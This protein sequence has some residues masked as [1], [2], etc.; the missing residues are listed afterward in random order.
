MASRYSDRPATRM[1]RE[2]R[3]VKND[4]WMR[5]FLRSCPVG[6]LATVHEGRP[7][8][9]SNLFVYDEA[10]HVIY[11]HTAR[12]GR[13]RAN[14]E[15]DDRVCFSASEMGRMLPADTALE[16]SVEYAGVVAFGRACVVE[17]PEEKR[18]GLQLLLD[19]YAPHLEAGRD[20]R[21]STP[22]ELDRTSV[23]RIDIEDWSGKKK[24]E[25][26]G[27]PGAFWYEDHRPPSPF[28][29]G[30]GGER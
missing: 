29:P 7:F 5:A 8:I 11:M 21:A 1:R 16:F 26:A 15:R 9:N 30:G 14:V 19:K 17:D 6:Y 10:A 2:D 27:F 20:Y 22:E 12:V 23:Y 13:T 28:R 4:D 3:A 25:D 18:R 24:E